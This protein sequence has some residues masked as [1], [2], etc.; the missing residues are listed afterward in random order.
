MFALLDFLGETRLSLLPWLLQEAMQ[1]NADLSIDTLA[2]V[3][4]RGVLISGTLRSQEQPEEELVH[5][6]IV[7]CLTS[8]KL[9]LSWL[10]R[11][12]HIGLLTPRPSPAMQDVAPVTLL[13]WAGWTEA[14]SG[15]PVDLRLA[16]FFP[17]IV[18]PSAAVAE[19]SQR[20]HVTGVTAWGA[21]VAARGKANDDHIKLFGALLCCLPQRSKDIGGTWSSHYKGFACSAE[22]GQ[23]GA[24]KLV[25]ITEDWSAIRIPAAMDYADNYVTGVESLSGARRWESAPHA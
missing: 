7:Q 3:G 19:I 14:V 4:Q 6:A 15:E 24:P 17:A 21:I 1:L 2:W 8:A 16:E 23:G 20:L 5:T 10:C 12:V 25:D 9:P 22:A 13:Q 11:C 18:N